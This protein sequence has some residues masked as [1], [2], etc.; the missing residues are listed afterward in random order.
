M[1]EVEM[2]DGRRSGSEEAARQR[3]KNQ[4]QPT[5]KRWTRECVRAQA[6]ARV[7]AR[8]DGMSGRWTKSGGFY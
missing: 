7:R 4:R 3:A 1:C 5:T 6:G 8:V 2:K